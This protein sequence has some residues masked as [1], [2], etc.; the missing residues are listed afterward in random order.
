MTARDDRARRTGPR[1]PGVDDSLRYR[2]MLAVDR[3]LVHALFRIRVE[4]RDRWPA[5]PFCLASNHH[6]GWDPLILVGIAPARPRITWFGPKEV[7]FSHRF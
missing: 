5:A 4:G 7:D 1:E 3:L 2:L 6:N